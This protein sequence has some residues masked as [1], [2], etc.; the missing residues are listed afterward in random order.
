MYE[1]KARKPCTLCLKARN[2]FECDGSLCNIA[3]GVHAHESV[4]VD[5][6]KAL[7]VKIL[8]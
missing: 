2:P 6:S 4:I 1:Q 5:S 8:E 7:R 3:N